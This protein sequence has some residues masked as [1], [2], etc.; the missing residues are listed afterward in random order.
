M[1]PH[2]LAAARAMT[3]ERMCVEVLRFGKYMYT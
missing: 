2:F 1:T 3:E